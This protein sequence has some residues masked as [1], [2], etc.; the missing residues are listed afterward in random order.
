LEESDKTAVKDALALSLAIKS[1]NSL[2]K[3]IQ[4]LQKKVQVQ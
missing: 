3:E 2:E 1:R 4:N